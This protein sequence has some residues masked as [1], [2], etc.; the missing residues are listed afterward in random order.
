MSLFR[1]I[2]RFGL[3]LS[4]VLIAADLMVA[5]WH[6]YM[7]APWTRDGR[8][9]VET[10]SIAP[11]V[12]GPVAAIKVADNRSVH[13]GD[14]LFVVDAE[15]FRIA[16]AEAEAIAESRRQELRLARGK[17]ERRTRLT[18]LA[19]SNE[20]RD[21][22]AAS[23]TVAAANYDQAVAALAMARLNLE[24]TVIR[25]PVNGYVT[26]LRLR[27]GD[28]VTAGQTA[29]VVVDQESFW[30]AAY[31]EETRLAQ[32]KPGAPVRIQL[33]GFET[34]LKGHVDSMSH[35]ISDEN[36][37][38][39]A[40]GLVSVN[41]VFTWVRLAQRIPVRIQIDEVPPD[42]G[43]AAG[44]TCTV[45]LDVPEAPGSDGWLPLRRLTAGLM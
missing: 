13:K 1:P 8:V 27:V 32:I 44:M 2:L 20:E 43:I 35:G 41:P 25:S 30:I 14:V 15:R 33:M 7:I 31:F 19:V 16:E 9:R 42:A 17:S 36:G 23:A 26:N 22:Y 21:Q 29:V 38:A 40:G 5:L 37:K 24:K 3:T 12:S 39:G 11:E 4:V 6:H 10:V 34:P 45:N 28:Y 18:N